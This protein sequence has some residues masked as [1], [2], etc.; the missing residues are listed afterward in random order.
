L[1]CPD[2]PTAS[3]L[4]Q[5][6]NNPVVAPSANLTGHEPAV[7]A[8]EVLEQLDGKISAVLDTGPCKY[9]KSSSV[10]KIGKK[11]LEVLRKGLYSD[12]QLRQK[13]TI[14]FLFVCTGN[15]CRSPMAEGLFRKYWAEK[16]GCKVDQ[17]EE[18][19]YKTLS[20]ATLSMAGVPVS[21]ESVV[22]CEK[23]GVDISEHRSQTVSEKLIEES[24][25]IFTMGKSH[26]D[27]ILSI[28]PDAAEKCFLLATD[29]D[30]PDPI[31]QSQTV[32]DKCAD[33]IE[34]YIK[35]IISELVI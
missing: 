4:L 15:T 25:L 26:R 32:Y 16:I 22:A 3:I 12:L 30:V 2:N 6:T 21:S 28:C 5:L 17:L 27:M 18:M 14:Q 7:T 24:D 35:N 9:Q 33:M 20:V 31:G 29:K 8:E 11:G 1:R 13:S 19:G 34:N 23:R 10:V